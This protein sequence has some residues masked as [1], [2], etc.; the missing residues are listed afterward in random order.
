MMPD[1][2]SSLRIGTRDSQLAL[3]QARHVQQL[4]RE[5]TP[6]WSLEQLPLYPI[7]AVGDKVLDVS[8]SELSTQQKQYG[9][10]VKELEQYLQTNRIDIAVHSLKDMPS[11]LP[12]GLAVVPI[13]ERA[14]VRDA[15]LQPQGLS[16][17]E[18]PARSVV[19]TSS[20]RRTAQLRRLRSDLTYTSIRGNVQTRLRKLEEGVVDGMILAE[21]G[22]NRLGLGSVM[23]HTFCPLTQLI[24][25]VG[26]GVLGV[27]Y[28]VCDTAIEARLHPLVEPCLYV[29]F[30]A[31]RT[32]MAELEGG[33]QL[34]LGA[35]CYWN[36]A[37]QHYE[38]VA[39]LLHPTNPEVVV[40]GSCCIRSL[41]EAAS[42]ARTLAHT[43]LAN[44]GIAIK[45]AI[46][47][48]TKS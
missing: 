46:A 26:Q 2:L 44:G 30:T 6:A 8:L 37:Q 42:Q 24:P 13:G 14:S 18:L 41:A 38:L 11:R 4:L 20:L 36:D 12:D 1:S 47:D 32:L 43:L 39:Q 45:Q 7:K 35:Y 28:R 22:L 34:P 29:A 5:Q 33:C 31:E 27:E 25:A 40:E 21:A 10:F 19:G 17:F 15:W 9:V 23:V 16:F 3:W 48:A